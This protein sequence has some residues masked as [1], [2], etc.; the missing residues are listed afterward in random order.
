MTDCVIYLYF[1]PK[2]N[3]PRYVGVGKT[4]KRA[5]EH[6]LPSVKSN[7]QLKAM[8]GKRIKEGFI[9]EPI[10]IHLGHSDYKIAQMIE[11]AVIST[12]GREDLGKGTLFNKTDGGDGVVGRI[13]SEE[14][15]SKKSLSQQ[16][17]CSKPEVRARKS[18]AGKIAQNR[19]EVKAK[20][21]I[22][23]KAVQ[24]RKRA[25]RMARSAGIEPTSSV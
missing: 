19:P 23:M 5:R 9:I 22:T 15:R 10:I 20:R 18:A 21:S 1:D 8:I 17:T 3:I 12:I 6:L 4:A 16:I 14:E 7:R 2:N 13:I 24:A 25:E 11:V